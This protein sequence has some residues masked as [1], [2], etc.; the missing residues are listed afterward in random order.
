MAALVRAA[1]LGRVDAATSS[2]AAALATRLLVERDV[3]GGYGSAQATDIGVRALLEA[4]PADGRPA[5]VRWAE[6][7]P[8]NHEGASGRAEVAPGRPVTIPL[9]AA[10]I[11]ARVAVSGPGVVARIE[12]QVLRS[13]R[14]VPDPGASPL[15]VQVD[16]PSGAR[17]RGAAT[18]HIGLRH[19][20]GRSAPVVVRVPLPPGASLA[21]PVDG[22]R[23][24]QGALY[25]RTTLDADPLPRVFAIP[26][27]FAL[28]GS[29]TLAEVTARIDDEEL[30]P[31][32]APARPLV[33]QPER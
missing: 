30:P 18:I 5:S 17:A 31:A 6:L 29:V 28:A 7:L 14:R 32:Y 15:H 3:D 22:V 27:R 9:P 24:V 8:G 21:E 20:L 11:G 1:R 13:F 12:R 23:Q 16:A 25:L 26:L 10:A 4:S 2:A 19:D 33:I